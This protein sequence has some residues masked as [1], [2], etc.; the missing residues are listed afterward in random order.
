MHDRS[1]ANAARTSQPGR[2]FRGHTLR[3]RRVLGKARDRMAVV[4]PSTVIHGSARAVRT[5][6][7]AAAAA[8]TALGCVPEGNAIR[9]DAGPGRSS[10]ATSVPRTPPPPPDLLK[11]TFVDDFDRAFP[12]S[13]PAAPSSASASPLDAAGEHDAQASGAVALVDPGPDWIATAP[14]FWHIEN[15]R[16]CGE[17]ARNH[18]I[19][20]KR[21]LPVNAII[22]FDAFSSSPEGDLK[23]EYWGD[24]RS[25]A[26]AISYTNATSYLTILGG[27]KNKLHVLARINE[28]GTDR[29]EIVIDP[30][31]DDKRE[32]P[33]VPGQGYHFKVERSDGH[34]VKWWIDGA[35]MLTYDDP[36]P[37]SGM[38]HDHFGFNDWEV[39]VCFDNV[40]VT[41]LP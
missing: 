27:W 36:A 3:A 7:L 12:T 38:G 19:W 21:T 4:D 17:H 24:G 6:V 22:E 13:S 40:R 2:E 25:Y 20:L 10:A 16:L 28:H 26:T 11:V 37:L 8:A 5:A 33:V 35:E 1:R 29:K 32:K 34:A 31:S 18:G 39:K 9:D 14:G 41:P 30:N 15:G 23:G